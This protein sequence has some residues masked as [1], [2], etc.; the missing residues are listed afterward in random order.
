MIGNIVLPVFFLYFVLISGYCSTLLNC[1]I[2]RFMRDTIY[3]KHF[4][5]ILSIYIFTFILNWYTFDSLEI[6]QVDEVNEVETFE[7]N[8]E[9]SFKNES[10]LKLGKW[11]LYSF[12]IYIVFLI[13]TKSEVNYILI[14]FA[15]TIIAIVLQ[16]VLKSVSS[17]SYNNLASKLF[18]TNKDY[19]SI[20]KNFV[21][22]TH[23]SVT[24][25]FFISMLLLL[26]GFYKYFLRQYA[27]H[28]HHFESPLRNEFVIWLTHHNHFCTFFAVQKFF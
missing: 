27:D 18:I 20:N 15:Y 9:L 25:G 21:I 17:I 3:F 24:S 4:L 5:I 1:G 23:N 19:N 10:L 28:A 12:A 14:F 26:F 13:S 2:Q 11:L 22:I 6:D 8:K 16:I 7:S